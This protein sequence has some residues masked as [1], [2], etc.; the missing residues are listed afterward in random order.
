M[1]RDSLMDLLVFYDLNLIKFDK[2]FEK[3]SKEVYQLKMKLDE[4]A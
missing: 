2:D 3:V 1:L 4:D